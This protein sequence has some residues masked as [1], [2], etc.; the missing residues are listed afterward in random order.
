MES[1]FSNANN[2]R[3]QQQQQQQ[4]TEQQ[5]K[6]SQSQTNREWVTGTVSAGL[7]WI[8]QQREQ[9]RR[10]A[11]EREVE[12]QRRRLYEAQHG[13]ILEDDQQLLANNNWHD[14]SKTTA[15]QTS[16]TG[17]GIQVDVLGMEDDVDEHIIPQVRL[18]EE[19]PTAPPFILSREQMQQLS[20]HALPISIAYS[21]WTR[22]Y[23]LVRDGDAFDAFLRKVEKQSHTLLVIRTTR[24]A[25]F[26]AYAESP[27]E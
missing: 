4:L 23:C 3:Q 26:G 19:P 16:I 9:R 13:T 7:G 14:L 17:S 18:E 25:I 22:L 15:M 8:Q 24:D 21:R 20:E 10:E 12:E 6:E 27:W 5:S 11:L 1:Q 2:M